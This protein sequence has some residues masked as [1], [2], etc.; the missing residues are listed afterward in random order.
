VNSCDFSAPV[1][2]K[3]LYYSIFLDLPGL[4]C[5][6][7]EEK[8]IGSMKGTSTHSIILKFIEFIFTNS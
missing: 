4:A 1:V 2:K 3:H 7:D 6:I 5:G 8:I